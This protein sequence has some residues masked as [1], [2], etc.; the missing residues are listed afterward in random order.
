MGWLLL[1]GR[2]INQL[3]DIRI[4]GASIPNGTNSTGSGD[5]IEMAAFQVGRQLK[6]ADADAVEAT[7]R[8]SRVCYT[9]A[10]PILLNNTRPFRNKRAL[11]PKIF[12]NYWK[13]MPFIIPRGPI[14]EQAASFSWP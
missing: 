14:H 8:L 7:K 9:P 3:S 6:E 13:I 4:A 2:P 10:V 12:H 1:R 5:R 11:G